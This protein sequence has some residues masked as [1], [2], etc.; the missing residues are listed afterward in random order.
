MFFAGTKSAHVFLTSSLKSV[1]SI[2]KIEE[3]PYVLIDDVYG[4]G[5]KKADALALNMGLK[6]NSQFRIEA[7]VMHF[8]AGRAGECS[9][10]Q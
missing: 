3:N 5:W 10:C 1:S 9:D 7:Y 4:I 8:L 6:H 2:K